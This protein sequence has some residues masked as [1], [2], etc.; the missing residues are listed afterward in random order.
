MTF[1]NDQFDEEFWARTSRKKERPLYDAT[2]TQGAVPAQFTLEAMLEAKPEA[3][4][5]PLQMQNEALQSQYEALQS[6]VQF[7]LQC[8]LGCGLVLVFAVVVYT[9]RQLRIQDQKINRQD[10]KINRQ[11]QTIRDLEARVTFLQ[12]LANDLQAEKKEHQKKIAKLEIAVERTAPLEQVVLK[13]RIAVLAREIARLKQEVAAID[14][15][16]LVVTDCLTETI[17]ATS[18]H[19]A[20]HKDSHEYR[21][22]GSLFEISRIIE[23][24]MYETIVDRYQL[25]AADRKGTSAHY[26]GLYAL[27]RDLPKLNCDS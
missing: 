23:A 24:G 21:V 2:G 13:R 9:R 7:G 12:V 18:N 1:E 5:S 15:D 19:A 14:A 4:G 10:E 17:E 6:Q 16:L 20:V 22:K 27:K 11:D 25:S 26:R 8:G 3:T